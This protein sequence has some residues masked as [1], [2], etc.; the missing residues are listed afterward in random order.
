MPRSFHQACNSYAKPHLATKSLCEAG[1]VVAHVLA[2]LHQANSSS[3]R[4][5]SAT[6]TSVKRETWSRTFLLS[7]SLRR[8]TTG[9]RRNLSSGPSLGRPC[10]ARGQAPAPLS[11]VPAPLRAGDSRACLQRCSSGVVL[12][13]SGQAWAPLLPA[14]LRT[15]QQRCRAVQTDASV[16]SRAGA[17]G[18]W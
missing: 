6:E 14:Q 1:E 15:L 7:S 11:S 13:R 3:A 18:G 4:K 10:G 2:A 16:T 9:V 8:G 17:P 12:S 5:H